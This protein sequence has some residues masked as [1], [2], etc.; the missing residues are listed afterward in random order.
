[1]HFFLPFLTL[2]SAVPAMTLP[3]LVDTVP[4]GYA[5]GEINWT[6]PI[7]EGGPEHIFQGT[8]Q[9][10]F[11]QVNDKRQEL[12]LPSLDTPLDDTVTA[13]NGTDPVLSARTDIKSRTFSNSICGNPQSDAATKAT[14]LEGV[15]YLEKLKSRCSNLPKTCGRISC[16]YNS[17]IWWCNDNNG[18]SEYAC[19]DFAPLAL[20]VADECCWLRR[21]SSRRYK[22]WM[23]SGSAFDDRN[24]HVD[25]RHARC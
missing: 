18:V 24:F 3:R 4:A 25:V 22:Y 1:M 8:A 6:M 11:A 2:V 17:A 14:I 5:V 23:T 13:S 12:G 10:V 15:R 9:Q 7:V 21:G 19:S 20:H 16:S